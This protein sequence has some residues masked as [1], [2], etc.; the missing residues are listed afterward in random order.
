MSLKFQNVKVCRLISSK[1]VKVCCLI[2]QKCHKSPTMSRFV[3]IKSR[4]PIINQL[5]YMDRILKRS[6]PGDT[7]PSPAKKPE[8]YA[9]QGNISAAFRG[10]LSKVENSSLIG[11]SCVCSSSSSRN[12]KEAS[13]SNSGV[14]QSIV[15]RVVKIKLM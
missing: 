4:V 10:Q 9:K 15:S 8:S 6:A 14:Q 7:S 11:R 3:Q 1:N 12:E 2:N 13:L 5:N